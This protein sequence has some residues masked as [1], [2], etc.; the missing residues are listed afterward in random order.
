MSERRMLFSHVRIDNTPFF[1]SPSRL[2]LAQA[3][4]APFP[5]SIF[6]YIIYNSAQGG[7]GGG[8]LRNR[9]AL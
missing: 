9:G 6:I 5:S 3:S 8:C 1:L 4:G 7:G 2:S